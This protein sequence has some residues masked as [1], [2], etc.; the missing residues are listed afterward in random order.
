VDLVATKDGVA[1]GPSS[2]TFDMGTGPITLAGIPASSIRV[3][4]N[5]TRATNPVD[6]AVITLPEIAPAGAERFD[7]HRSSDELGQ[8]FT[9]VGYGQNSTGST[10]DDPEGFDGRKRKGENRLTLSILCCRRTLTAAWQC[11]TRWV[12]GD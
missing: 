8:I 12:I 10:A 4:P 1:D 7:L 9:L 6:L 5:W 11:T 3:H 2:V